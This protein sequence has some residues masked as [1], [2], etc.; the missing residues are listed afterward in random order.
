M[1]AWESLTERLHRHAL[2]DDED[3]GDQGQVESSVRTQSPL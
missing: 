1:A 3:R 2:A